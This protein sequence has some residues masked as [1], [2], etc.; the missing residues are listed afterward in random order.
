MSTSHRSRSTEGIDGKDSVGLYLD[1]IAKTPLLTAEEEVM[2]AREIEA[3]LY[4]EAILDGTLTTKERGGRKAVKATQEELEEIV[5]QGRAAMKRF[6]TANLRLVVSV[7]R[8]Y[9]RSQMPLLDLVQEGNTGLI[10]AVEKF[11]YTKGFKFSTYATWW[12][13]QSISRGIA[14]QSRIVRLP[15]HVA[16]QINQVSATRR[17]LERKLGREPEVIEI[18]DE[19]GLEE[20]RIVELLRLARDH[21]S[22]DAPVEEDG[23]TALGDLLARDTT[24]GPDEVVLDAEDRARLDHMLDSLDERSADVVRRRYGLLDGRQAKLAD[25]ASVWGITAERV[26]QIERQAIAKLRDTTLAA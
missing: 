7:A 17:N 10:R 20:E 9:G 15:V 12:V 18:A 8:K 19:L 11:D 21:V 4:A 22:L 5:E 23:D 2:L 26:R 13:R 24:P 3:G 6:V 16:E 14:Q 25:I 1:G